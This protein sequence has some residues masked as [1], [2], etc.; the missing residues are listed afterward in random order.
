MVRREKSRIVYIERHGARAAT[1][2]GDG[3]LYNIQEYRPPCRHHRGDIPF[4]GK[5]KRSVQ[6]DNQR[7]RIEVAQNPKR[8]CYNLKFEYSPTII[9]ERWIRSRSRMRDEDEATNLRIPDQRFSHPCEPASALKKR[10]GDLLQKD[11]LWDLVV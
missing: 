11:S 2:V 1:D 4:K 7:G 8:N 5:W 3:C 9:S 6:E 10:T